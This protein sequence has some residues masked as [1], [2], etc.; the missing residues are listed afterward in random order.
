MRAGDQ[1]FLVD[2][3]TVSLAPPERDLWL[4]VES[5]DDAAVYADAAGREVDNDAIE[6][7]RLTWDL[8]DLAE[9]LKLLRL[10]HGENDDT[11]RA[12]KSVMN[13]V[14]SSAR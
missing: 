2:W 4:V 3:D 6:F 7:F 10:P 13:C 5:A 12:T 9:Y 8:K 11:R 14:T 1:R